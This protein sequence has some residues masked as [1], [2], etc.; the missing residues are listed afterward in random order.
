MCYVAAIPYIALALTAVSG[1][2]AA[3]S[4]KK[5]GEYQ[6]EV[7]QQNKEN[8]NYRA[9]MAATQGSLAEEQHR[10]KVRQM[11]G[12]QRANLAA[13]GIDLQSGTAA[14]M[15]DET[16][17]NG[18]TDA[19]TLRFNAMQQ[20]WGYRVEAANDSNQGKFAKW[21]GQRQATGTYLSTGASMASQ[22]YGMKTGS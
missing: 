8:D 7:A 6:A 11:V 19:L 18:E 5:S 21:S 4:Q 9:E 13:N 20:A 14:D 1:A 3:D 22:A 2:Y 10:A 16:Q 15:I 17:T 12:T